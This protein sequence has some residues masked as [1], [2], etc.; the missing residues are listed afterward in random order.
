MERIAVNHHAV[1]IENDGGRQ[2]QVTLFG[3]SWHSQAKISNQKSNYE[4]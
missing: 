3:F 2:A 1:H 4:G